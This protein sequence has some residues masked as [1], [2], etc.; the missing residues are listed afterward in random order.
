[1]KPITGLNNSASPT[2]TACDQSTPE[3][4]WPAGAIHSLAIPTPMIEPIKA[5][6]EL[7]GMPI[8]QVPRFHT[9]AAISREKI[10][11]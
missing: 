8:A 5:C 3:V 4:A 10:I 7:F 6:E 1:M 11:A 2:L 9:M